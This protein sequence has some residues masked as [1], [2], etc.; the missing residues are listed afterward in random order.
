M[1]SS[2]TH[3]R[4]AIDALYAA[5]LWFLDQGRVLDAATILRSMILT[6]PD[7]E[8]AWLG[9]GA[10]H[11]A[12]HQPSLALELYAGGVTACRSVRCQIARARIFSAQGRD[13]DASDAIDRAH[14]LLEARDDDEDREALVALLRHER[15]ES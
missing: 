6:A 4:V 13:G 1:S 15:G 9:L 14:A 8:R 10:A 7:D 11:E 12:L 5:G 2:P 3:N